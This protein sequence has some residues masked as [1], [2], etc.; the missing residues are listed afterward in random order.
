MVAV[1]PDERKEP[2]PTSL[3][4]FLVGLGFARTKSLERPARPFLTAVDRRPTY[5]NLPSTAGQSLL[6]DQLRFLSTTRVI[7]KN[8]PLSLPP[9]RF[10]ERERHE[11][12]SST[13]HIFS[14]DAAV[15]FFFFFLNFR[16]RIVARVIRVD[17]NNISSLSTYLLFYPSRWWKF[18]IDDYYALFSLSLF[19]EKSTIF[20][21]PFK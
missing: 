9:T 15:F 3:K 18:F 12:P 7:P 5:L 2:V 13:S 10:L 14:F 8:A 20:V 6:E 1:S 19:K 21:I 11:N 4:V 16:P 17:S